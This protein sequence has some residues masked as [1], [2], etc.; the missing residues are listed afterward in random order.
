MS[1]LRRHSMPDNSLNAHRRHV[2][3]D[4]HG[5]VMKPIRFKPIRMQ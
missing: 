5:F 4:R 2:L 1:L 3:D